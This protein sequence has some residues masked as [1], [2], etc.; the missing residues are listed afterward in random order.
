MRYAIRGIFLAALAISLCTFGALAS[1]QS[2]RAHSSA[3]GAS[4]PAGQPV[5]P[6]HK[7]AADAKPL[8][9]ILPASDFS[10]RPLVARAYQIASEIP[11]VLAQQPCYCHCDK[12][13]GHTSLLDCFASSHTAGCGICMGE[14]FFAYKL[15]KEGK[16]PAEIRAAIIRGDWKTAHVD[17]FK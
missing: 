4:K 17:P 1:Q 14:T 16:T 8:P 10:D 15:T 11:T 3:S 2:A 13:F 12:E 7:S 5:P 9:R 6:Y